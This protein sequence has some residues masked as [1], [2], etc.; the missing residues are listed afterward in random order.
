[1]FLHTLHFDLV[2][3]PKWSYLANSNSHSGLPT[4]RKLAR[5]S[6]PI[7]Q[8]KKKKKVQTNFKLKTFL[9]CIMEVRC[10][11]NW[12]T[13][14]MKRGRHLQ[15]KMGCEQ[16]LAGA[17]TCQIPQTPLWRVQPEASHKLT[18]GRCELAR[19]ESNPE[20]SSKRIYTPLHPLSVNLT[21]CALKMGKRLHFWEN[22]LVAQAWWGVS[23]C[24]Q[25]A[26]SQALITFQDVLM[27]EGQQT[28]YAQGADKN[29]LPPGQGTERKPSSRGGEARSKAELRC[30]CGEGQKRQKP[31][32]QNTGT[33][34]LP[35][36]EG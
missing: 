21:E 18:K 14:N 24:C 12:L 19:E 17:D 3:V 25:K 1:M 4:R 31:H 9:E 8:L 35:K 11:C 20:A 28:L 16:L 30:Q 10:W 34:H 36:A 5:A 22:V 13:W 23:M 2:N 26:R 33:W 29:P 27:G 6:L 32:S 7:L 15:G